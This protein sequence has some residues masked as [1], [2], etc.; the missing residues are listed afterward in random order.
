MKLSKEQKW[1]LFLGYLAFIVLVIIGD[2]ASYLLGR[3][4]VVSASAVTNLQLASQ[5]IL[6]ILF[7]AFWTSTC[8][9]DDKG[10]EES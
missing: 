2:T 7:M 8:N 4:G 5:G 10:N 9:R 1:T 6:F 3:F